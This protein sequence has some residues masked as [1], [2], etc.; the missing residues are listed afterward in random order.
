MALWRWGFAAQ[1]WA[2]RFMAH[3]E[4]IRKRNWQGREFAKAQLRY[5]GRP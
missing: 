5:G 1:G 4:I 3:A 2:R